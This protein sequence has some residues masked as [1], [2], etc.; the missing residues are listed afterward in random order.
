MYKLL[1]SIVPHNSGELVTDSAKE[2]G[3]TGG[4]IIM[5]RGTAS[6]NIIQLFGFGDL[7]KDIAYIVA[8]E[9]IIPSAIEKIAKKCESK[10]HFG[11]LF[12]LDVEGFI[13]G[14]QK[15]SADQIT[16]K[17]ENMT[18]SHEMINI[19]VNKGFA[20]DVMDAARKA[21]A[22][23][24]TIISAK[25]TAKEGD[26]TFLGVHIVPEKE[27]LMILVPKDKKD[28]IVNAIAALPCLSE[29]GSGIVF[30]NPA[31]NFTVLGKK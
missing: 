12:T 18:N 24:G 28:E 25:G 21:G 22:G 8:D 9:K 1:I 3:A 5:G 19:I 20:E 10:K 6:S 2:T 17:E 7:S 11:V 27:M 16:Q 31:S 13:K 4:T 29:A 30:C 23:G 15:N 26:S 14:G